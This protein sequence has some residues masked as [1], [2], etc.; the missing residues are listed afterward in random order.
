MIYGYCFGRHRHAAASVGDNIYV[1][2]GMN[3]NIVLGDFY[4]LNMSSWEWK[5]INS[6][7]DIPS[8]RYSCSLAAIGQ[9]LYFFGGRDA[10][11]A[12]GDLHVFCLV[13]NTWT[14]QKGF[15]D[16]TPRFSHSMTAVG[17]W[18]VILGG[19]PTTHH[20]TDLLFLDVEQMASQRVPLM[21]APLDML[22]VR[23]TTTL[24]GTRL[25]VVGGGAAC[26]AF[27]AKFNVP[28]S[29]D[30]EP[31]LGTNSSWTMTESITVVSTRPE[32]L[33]T[34]GDSSAKDIWSEKRTWIF[35][36]DRNSAKVGKDALKQLGWLDQ[37]RKPKVLGEGLHVAFPVTEEAALY[38]Q[39]AGSIDMPS[40]VCRKLNQEVFQGL[41]SKL[42]ATGGE[43]AEM[44]LACDAHRPISPSVTLETDV[45]KLLQEVGL[46]HTLLEEL[47]K[48]YYPAL[49]RKEAALALGSF[50]LFM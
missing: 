15:E 9:K 34:S 30:V 25:F 2:G 26:F 33:S 29:V 11:R 27:G 18:L 5:C 31:F 21:Q 4:V 19:C 50:V 28:F 12:Y 37:A 41:I 42:V 20:G 49:H 46:P 13:T 36:I 40:T 38:L 14:E 23:H 32:E 3:E 1:F 48:R 17:K 10:R 22:L 47:P 43:V 45:F 44:Q 8:P 7:G 6:R 16:L 24:V 39:D 35:R